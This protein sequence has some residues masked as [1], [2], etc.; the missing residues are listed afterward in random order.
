MSYTAFT[1][2]IFMLVTGLLYFIMPRRARWGVLLAAS[3]VF[4]FLSSKLLLASLLATTVSIYVAGLALGRI[5]TQFQLAKK[6]A[7]KEE[8]KALRQKTAGRKKRVVLLAVLFNFGLL[9]F[10]KYFNFFGETVNSV[11]GLFSDLSPV[12]HLKLLMPL[13]IS[14]YT[15]QSISYVVDVYR[16]KVE[17][18]R[19]FGRLALF[20]S[21]FP[22]IVEGP[23]GRYGDLAHQLYEPHA[24]SCANLLQG[25]EM[26]LWGLFKK[27]VV[28]DRAGIFVDAVFGSSTAYTGLPVILAVLL[29]TIQIYA[30]F[31]GV[32]D[33]VRGVARLFGIQL[34]LNFRRPFFSASVQEFWRRWHITLGAWLRDYVFYPVSLS[35]PILTLGKSAKKVF[36]GHAG[37]QLPAICALFFVWFGNGLWHGAGWKFIVY[38]LYYY[39]IMTIGTLFE[40][41][42]AKILEKLHIDRGGHNL[43]NISDRADLCAGLFWHA[44]LPRAQP[45][46]GG[47][48][49]CL[50]VP[51]PVFGREPASAEV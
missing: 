39:V 43:E 17:P 40:P 2:I 8:K 28:A 46:Q 3:Y 41:L 32:M 51:R 27:M 5:Q 25:M 16:G 21:F 1:F 24:P 37:R 13:G 33:I 19:H 4:Y 47:G 38:G 36:K 42:S 50:H 10:F 12:P 9:L 6:T 18:D 11:F 7:A 49:L 23:I 20:V 29:Y 45:W 44:D 30:D 31:S 48:R 15:L 26:I 34:A 14:Y 35:K 22:Q